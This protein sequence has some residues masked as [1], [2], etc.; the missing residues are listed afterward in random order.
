M[1]D[2]TIGTAMDNSA[3]KPSQTRVIFYVALG[4]FLFVALIS[5]LYLT[6]NTQNL[7][8]RAETADSCQGDGKIIADPGQ[9]CPGGFD[10][11]G[12]I[13]GGSTGGD[14]GSLGD[15]GNTPG[16]DGGSQQP[17]GGSR[18]CCQRRDAPPTEVPP[19]PPLDPTPTKVTDEPPTPTT[20]TPPD[21]PTPTTPG[22]PPVCGDN[23]VELQLEFACLKDC[24][25]STLPVEPPQTE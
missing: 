13:D 3:N 8:K 10:P 4:I 23:L 9:S 19:P 17:G 21:D 11:I 7:G 25:S 15:G 24:S 14:G 16:G 20:S 1:E 5:G 12:V 18:L 22:S 6:Q 2:S